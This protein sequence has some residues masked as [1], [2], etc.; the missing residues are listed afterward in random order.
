LKKTRWLQQGPIRKHPR[1]P[2]AETWHS[3]SSRLLEVAATGAAV[4]RPRRSA[5]IGPTPAIMLGGCAV[6][7][8]ARNCGVACQIAPSANSHGW[9]SATVWLIFNQRVVHLHVKTF[10]FRRQ[11]MR[12]GSRA[13]ARPPLAMA[14]PH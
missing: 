7:K 3:S 11:E 13:F 4:F 10:A 9:K 8:M 6:V 14:L 1:A 2:N 5:Y 12:R